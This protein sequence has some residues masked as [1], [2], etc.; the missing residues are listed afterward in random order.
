MRWRV[1]ARRMMVASARLP[2]LLNPLP[3]LVSRIDFVL[4]RPSVPPGLLS[5]RLVGADPANR[6]P[7]AAGLLWPSD[8][9]GLVVG[10]SATWDAGIAVEP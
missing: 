8:H 6:A 2:R 1:S 3:T 4:T 7:S 10:P 9:A 5:T